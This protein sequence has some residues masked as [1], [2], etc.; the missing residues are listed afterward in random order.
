MTLWGKAFGLGV[1]ICIMLC[2][3]HVCYLT[4]SR[5][6]S[7]L[8]L[9]SKGEIHISPVEVHPEP[10]MDLRWS[11]YGPKMAPIWPQD[12]P[13]HPKVAPIWPQEAPRLG[14]DGPNNHYKANGTFIVLLL[15]GILIQRWPK[16]AP[17]WPQIGPR[18][19]K[20]APRGPFLG[21]DTDRGEKGERKG[22][23]L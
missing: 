11:R 9:W 4:A 5:I 7:G 23:H 19:P 18:W 22:E 15:G 2:Q 12:G 17:S 14:Q 8:G 16:M 13:R 1:W 10:K 6:P 20:M 21:P 3:P